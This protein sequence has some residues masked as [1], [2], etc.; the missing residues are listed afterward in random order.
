LR[1]LIICEDLPSIS[2]ATSFRIMNSIKYLSTKYG[3][4]ITLVAYKHEI[5]EKEYNTDFLERYCSV[6]TVN[7]PGELDLKFKKRFVYTLKNMLHFRNIISK[8]F[9]LFNYLYSPKMA[10][11]IT[12]LD[13]EKNFDVIFINHHLLMYNSVEL[14]TP[15]V[16][17]VYA[18]TD[19]L[20]KLMLIK[21]NYSYK[22]PIFAKLIL[23]KSHERRFSKMAAC[24]TVTSNDM[25][26][27]KQSNPDLNV[28]VVP[29]GIDTNY[30]KPFNNDIS[31]NLLPN[32]VFTG[33]MNNIANV[34]SIINFYLDVFPKIRS[35]ISNIKINIVGRDPPKELLNLM[36]DK[37]VFV[38]GYVKDI[39]PYLNNAS[40]IIFPP[41]QGGGMRTRLLEA[42]AMAKPIVSDPSNLQG[43]NAENK[44]DILIANNSEDFASSVLCLLN[45]RDFSYKLGYNARLYVEGNHSWETMADQFNRIIKQVVS[46]EKMDLIS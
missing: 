29:L 14:L 8:N 46:T 4:S 22:L 12:K 17:E 33:N 3:H 43:I 39:R 5:R 40:V 16:L 21:D 18:L 37:S 25:K 31:R 10:E 23:S 7:I 11:L 24:I 35:H 45:D 28:K 44:R 34:D 30:F 27:L 2:N 38:T 15:Q 13:K 32:L 26:I 6:V 36:K 19:T 42:M 9:C 20:K 41:I 1:I